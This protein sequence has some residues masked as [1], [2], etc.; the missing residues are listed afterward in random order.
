[1]SWIVIAAVYLLLGTGFAVLV[2]RSSG[3]HKANR[4]TAIF[5]TIAIVWPMG[6]IFVVYRIIRSLLRGERRT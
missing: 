1:V 3:D 2:N 5:I 6:I 4:E